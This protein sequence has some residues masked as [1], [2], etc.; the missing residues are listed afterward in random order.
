VA[1]LR[2]AGHRC[3]LLAPVHAGS[4]LLGPGPSEV[5]ELLPWDSAEVAAL[6]AGP[7][8]PSGPFARK[9]ATFD[10]ALAYTRTEALLEGLRRSL[11][12]VVALDPNPPPG[13]GHA[14]SWLARP[15]R[16]WGLEA[17]AVPPTHEPTQPEALAAGE[18]LGQLPE[19]FL[20]LHAGSGS[21]AK[22]WPAERFAGLA[23]LLS[24]SR[25]WLLVEGPVEAGSPL[26]G[27]TVI[28]RGL[29]PRV[30]GAVLARAGLYVG[31]DTGV[32]H[33][34]AAWGAPTLALFGPTDSSVWSPIGERVTVLA[35][36]TRRM[37]DL[38]LEAV[39]E[40]AIR[41]GGSGPPGS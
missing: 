16:Q 28:A 22:N 13:A 31:N 5:E 37:D 34:A 11:P 39:R 23:G 26:P 10:V 19:R 38:P 2:A 36:P 20:A 3:A 17:P 21:P 6:L 40:A 14:S 41:S 15:L 18:L 24:P 7:P 35:S 25:R 8:L 4:V 12:H 30:L 1:A 9:L 32:S 33:L 27:A 29:P